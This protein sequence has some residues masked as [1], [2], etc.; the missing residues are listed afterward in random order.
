MLVVVECVDALVPA[1]LPAIRRT[2]ERYAAALV[3][4]GPRRAIIEA[5]TAVVVVVPQ[6]GAKD[7]LAIAGRPIVLAPALALAVVAALVGR[8]LD[9]AAAAV[10]VVFVG[11]GAIA[12]AEDLTVAVAKD[13]A[14]AA[15]AARGFAATVAAL[16]AIPIVEVEIDA[17]PV[18]E[19][20]VV[21]ADRVTGPAHATVTVAADV[22]AGSAVVRIPEVVDARVPAPD[23]MRLIQV[24]RAAAGRVSGRRHRH[25]VVRRIRKR[26]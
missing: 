22:A 2:L 20:F 25:R 24:R 5:P 11:I 18:A 4:A 16:T 17:L 10:V 15:F 9:A 19:D 26:L 6:V 21:V 23:L 7:T 3:A 13:L 14:H 12:A 8:A 1:Q